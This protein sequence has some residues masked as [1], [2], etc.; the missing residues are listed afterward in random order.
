MGLALFRREAD[1]GVLAVA[2]SNTVDHDLRVVDQPHE[3][4]AGLGDRLLGDV[5]EDNAFA[6]PGNPSGGGRGNNAPSN[7][8]LGVQ[9]GAPTALRERRLRSAEEACRTTIEEHNAVT[10]SLQAILAEAGIEAG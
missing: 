2:G 1:L 3:A 9:Q 6:A 8:G 4:G 5:A 7:W 10:D